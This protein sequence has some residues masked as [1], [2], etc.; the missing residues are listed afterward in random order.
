[1]DTDSIV[2]I[3][4]YEAERIVVAQILLRGEGNLTEVIKTVD[5]IGGNAQ[6]A[7]TLLVERRIQTD[8]DG[9]L[10]FLNATAGVALLAWS[11]IP[12]ANTHHRV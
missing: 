4:T 5:G 2:H 7:Q 9:F 3:G 12:V 1:M 6:I 8:F 10:E 11:L